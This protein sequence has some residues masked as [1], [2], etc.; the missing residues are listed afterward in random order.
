MRRGEVAEAASGLLARALGQKSDEVPVDLD[1]VTFDY[2]CEHES[3]VF[4]ED[5]T[6]GM[7]GP[8]EILGR[9]ELLLGRISVCAAL[10]Q[11]DLRRFRFTVAHELG[12]WVLH[13]SLAMASAEQ[14]E[15]FPAGAV[16]VSTE[17]SLS[18]D[19]GGK[20]P[21]EW[22]ADYFASHLLLPRLALR[23][24]FGA[25]FGV[26]PSVRPA[27]SSLRNHSRHVA[28]AAVRELLPLVDAFQ[29]SVEATAIALEES[30]LVIPEPTLL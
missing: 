16:F 8:H 13:R 11:R 29:A 15:L 4:V 23:R 9:T 28:R 7:D 25:R 3:L 6:L 27:G 12:H 1:A 10:K 2:L 21:E 22:Q 24:E 17:S 18:L 30:G 5:E 14:G 20:A 19:L 26:K